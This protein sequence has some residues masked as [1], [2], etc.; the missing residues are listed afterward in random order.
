ML[1]ESTLKQPQGY[2]EGYRLI[3]SNAF[4]EACANLASCYADSADSSSPGLQAVNLKNLYPLYPSLDWRHCPVHIIQDC[5]SLGLPGIEISLFSCISEIEET[6][7]FLKDL[8]NLPLQMQKKWAQVKQNLAIT[9]ANPGTD[10]KFWERN[11]DDVIYSVRLTAGYRAHLRYKR[12]QQCWFA[13]AVG[14]HASMG[15]D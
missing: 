3:N 10:F 6:N 5:K 12:S 15:H 7:R 8:K 14:S 9:T 13:D 4:D 2:N 1:R 11:G